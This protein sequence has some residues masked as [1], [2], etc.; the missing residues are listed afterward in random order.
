MYRKSNTKQKLGFPDS[1]VGKESTRNAGDPGSIPESG[2][3]AGGGIGYRF[4][5]SWVSLVAQLVKNLRANAGDLGLSPGLGR[6][7]GE[8]NDYPFSIL[9]REFHGYGVT[10]GQD[11][12]TFT[13]TPLQGQLPGCCVPV[14]SSAP[15]VPSSQI[16]H[17]NPSNPESDHIIP[18][19]KIAKCFPIVLRAFPTVWLHFLPPFSCSLGYI[20]SSF[21][22]VS[23]RSQIHSCSLALCPCIANPL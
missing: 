22:V 12:G 18:Q 6:S 15:A 21:L 5:Y 1:S 2:R 20:Y 10:N 3:S 23:W 14:S 11:C 16:C 7:P 13:F 17:R 19:I 4:Q 9:A 8:G